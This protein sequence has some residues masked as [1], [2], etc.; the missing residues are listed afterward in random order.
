MLEQPALESIERGGGAGGHAD[1][2]IEIL[3]VVVG[4]LGRDLKLA[5]GFLRRIAGR[6]QAQDL[7]FTRC[8]SGQPLGRVPAGGL[9]GR[10]EHG[11][12][13]VG[14]QLSLPDGAAQLRGR[15]RIA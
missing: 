7:D 10:G 3:D 12:D 6:D 5:S 4:G 15:R 1:L 2:G 14:T 8:Q 9:A 13:G 11:L